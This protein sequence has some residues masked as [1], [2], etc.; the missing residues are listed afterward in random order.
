[1]K[2]SKGTS[3][4]FY[5]HIET[6]QLLVVERR[7]DGAILGSCPATEPLRDLGSCECT[8]HN[9]LWVQENSN[10]LVLHE[11][12]QQKSDERQQPL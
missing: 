3:K 9:N 6:G 1:M 10:K 8:S 11:A 4:A 7:A 2:K 12:G 5:R